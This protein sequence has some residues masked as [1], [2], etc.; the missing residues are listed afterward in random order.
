MGGVS[1][2]VGG[3]NQEL[4]Q[5]LSEKEEAVG[6]LTG[7]GAVGVYLHE[8]QLVVLVEDVLPQNRVLVA[9]L[10]VLL[11]RDPSLQD[12]CGMDNNQGSVNFCTHSSLLKGE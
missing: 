9:E 1:A 3:R 5:G 12:L 4:G 2:R 7:P 11:D 6:M 8:G 10:R